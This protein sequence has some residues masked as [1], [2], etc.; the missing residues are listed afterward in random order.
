MEEREL[1]LMKGN[2]AIAEAAIRAGVDALRISI[3]LRPRHGYLRRPMP[4]R[5]EWRF[6]VRGNFRNK[7]GLRRRSY[8][9]QS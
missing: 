8:R 3:T 1:R 7:H 2:E 9:T 4:A 5:T 6:S